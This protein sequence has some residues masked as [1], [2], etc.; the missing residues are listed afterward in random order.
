[1]GHTS[2]SMSSLR[3]ELTSEMIRRYRQRQSLAT[4]AAV[5]GV[6]TRRDGAG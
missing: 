3:P 2:Y 1:M 5:L 6:D 4:I